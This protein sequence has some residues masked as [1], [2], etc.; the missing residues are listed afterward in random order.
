MT[1]NAMNGNLPQVAARFREDA[2]GCSPREATLVLAAIVDAEL[3]R[4]L[5]CPCDVDDEHCNV[6]GCRLPRLGEE[7]HHVKLDGGNEFH[8]C[9]DCWK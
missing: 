8:Y 7:G 9:E 5:S 3:T 2:K 4:L 1:H 6:C